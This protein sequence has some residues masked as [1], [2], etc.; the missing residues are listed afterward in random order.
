LTVNEEYKADT[1]ISTIPWQSWKQI[2]QLPSNI[3]KCIDELVY[4]SIDVDYHP[5]N[6]KSSAHWIYEANESVYYH[7]MM[8]RCNFTD[9][10]GYWT[11]ANSNRSPV[12]YEKRFKNEFAYPV[13]TCSKPGVMTSILDWAKNKGILPIGRWG[14]WEHINSDQA[15][16]EGINAA[17]NMALRNIRGSVCTQ[18]L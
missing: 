1:I 2:S 16:L 11:E 12:C 3:S 17:K 15:V 4:T 7:R 14:R 9:C 5:E 8:C 13:N 10:V 6:P 18:N